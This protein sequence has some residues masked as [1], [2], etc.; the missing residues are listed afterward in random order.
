MKKRQ[1][2]PEESL[3]RWQKIL[4]VLYDL[5]KGTRKQLRFEDIVVAAFERFPET[6]H[7]RGY[8][9][10]P[11]SGDLVHKPL[12]DMRPRGL[13]TANRK[14]FSLTDK[15]IQGARRL[16]GAVSKGGD[17]HYKPSREIGREIERITSSDAFNLFAEGKKGDILDTDFFQYLG[18]SVHTS[19]NEFLNRMAMIE[20]AVK[21]ARSFYSPKDSKKLSKYH[22]FMLKRFESIVGEVSGR[23]ERR[24]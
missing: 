19:R 23:K 20:H 17:A 16:K 10:Y 18:V 12:Y 13:L 21:E 15:G 7:L 9:N 3:P 24:R 8:K 11:D 22:R 4:L 1:R 5:S 6:F 14:M 2:V